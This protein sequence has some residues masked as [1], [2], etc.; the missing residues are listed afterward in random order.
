MPPLY[1]CHVSFSGEQGTDDLRSLFDHWIAE[2]GVERQ[3]PLDPGTTTSDGATLSSA[4]AESPDASAIRFSLV[5]EVEDG[6]C[7]TSLTAILCD[8]VSTAWIDV[9]WTPGSAFATPPD[10]RPPDLATNLLTRFDCSVGESPIRPTPIVLEE[11]NVVGF[12]QQLQEPDRQVPVV[13]VAADRWDD[14]TASLD[15]CHDLQ[16]GIMGLAPVLIL[17]RAANAAMNE[18][19]G[20]D[21]TVQSG[22]ISCFSPGLDP[23]TADPRA[24]RS[25]PRELYVS[26]PDATIRRISRVLLTHALKRDLPDIYRNDF[27]RQPGFPRHKGIDETELLST[28]YRLEDEVAELRSNF[29]LEVLEHEETTR[30][31]DDAQSRVSYLQTRLISVKGQGA[32]DPTPEPA[33]PAAADSCLEALSYAGQYLDNVV[34]GDTA[35]SASELDEYPQSQVWGAK[36]WRALRTLQEYATAKL[37]DDFEGNLFN[38]C[39]RPPDGYLPLITRHDVAMQ[40]GDATDNDPTRRNARYFPV[41]EEVI[42]DGEAY[43]CAHIKITQGGSPAPR[44]HFLDDTTGQTGN[45]YVGYFGKHLP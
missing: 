17:T 8:D 16:K 19:L 13:V 18:G 12:L 4:R 25:V 35:N 26:N 2:Q 30:A 24:H 40:E 10:I 27:I 7:E 21:L 45:I 32:F 6:Q 44:I 36:A 5:N 3:L 22:S 41:P 37:E 1:R 33:I 29:E 28:L 42:A 23:L 15:R 38:F 14:W 34:I 43:M 20:S 39:A 9:E 31:L 11:S